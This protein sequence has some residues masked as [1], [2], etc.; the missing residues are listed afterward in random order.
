MSIDATTAAGMVNTMDFQVSG[1]YFNA[2]PWDNITVYVRA[3]DARALM[4]W[5]PS[6]FSS[7]RI[8]LTDSAG[9]AALPRAWNPPFIPA[10]RCTPRHQMPPHGSGRPSPGSSRGFSPSS[11]PSCSDH[12]R[13]HPLHHTDEPL[14]ADP[15]VRDAAGD[16]LRETAGLPHDIPGDPLRILALALAA[17]AAFSGILVAVF[18][19]AGLYVGPGTASYVLGGDMIYPALLAADLVLALA[20]S[21]LF[22]LWP[23]WPGD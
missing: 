18:S 21:S 3:E 6:W 17:A 15:G 19:R 1:V 2:A 16:R 13:G 9:R 10:G 4:E 23:P 11:F 14:P 12:R 8:Y 5:D 22:S 20:P 7:A